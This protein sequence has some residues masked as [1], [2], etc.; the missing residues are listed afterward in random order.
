MVLT[1]LTMPGSAKLC[2]ARGVL[3]RGM[4]IPNVTCGRR[5]ALRRPRLRSGFYIN[6]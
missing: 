5:L 3:S 1:S 4:V 6:P 2:L